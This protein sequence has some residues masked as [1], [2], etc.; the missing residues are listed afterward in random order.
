MTG[1]AEVEEV[2]LLCVEVAKR[3]G[4]MVMEESA[5]A[6]LVGEGRFDA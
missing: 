4:Q 3:L 6:L 1:F 5:A 2:L